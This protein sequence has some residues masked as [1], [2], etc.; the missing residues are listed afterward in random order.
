MAVMLNFL[1]CGIVVTG[2]G[3]LLPE[4]GDFYGLKVGT[5][6]LI[7][8]TGVFGYVCSTVIVE[9]IHGRLG[10]RGIAYLSPVVRL[11]AMA[12]LATGPS[13][14]IAL[15]GYFLMGFGIGLSDAGFSAWAA[16]APYASIVQG[17]MH[18]SYSLG[19][20]LGPL[21]A[22]MMLKRSFKWYEFY[23]TTGIL[24][25]VELLVLALAFRFDNADRY[26]AN[27]GE[28]DEPHNCNALQHR[29]TWICGAFCFF[30]VGLE[31]CFTDW[32]AVFMQ[33]ARHAEPTTSSLATSMFWIG[34]TSGRFTLGP[35]TQYIGVRTA[36]AGY[37]G[38]LM[39]LQ[40]LFTVVTSVTA[41]L[42]LLVG[43][44]LFCG[45][46]FP[47]GLLLLSSKLPQRA[48]V[49]AVAA[50]SALGQVGAGLAPF[51]VGLMA[52]SFGIKYLL[53]VIFAL[54][55]G[56]LFVW[57]AFAK[58]P[59]ATSELRQRSPAE[60]KRTVTVV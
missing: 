38:S 10:L 54:A 51:A 7:F 31:G 60:V 20:I 25:V 53:N 48:Q 30:Y 13:F 28:S 56:A 32:I 12:V 40:V 18:G 26:T 46:I 47:S 24:L 15:A 16:N 59:K 34:M 37:I 52:D 19:S 23:S 21:V 27:H 14:T 36:V 8:P 50:V 45:P 57:V 49:G 43:S 55:V 39:V 9:L 44:G 1:V 22:D 2:I 58:L 6:S 4:I 3:V 41:S 11:L 33:R 17:F 42:L 5:T 35:L 29:A